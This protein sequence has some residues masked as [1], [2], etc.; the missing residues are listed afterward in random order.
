MSFSIVHRNQA[1]AD[2]GLLIFVR[3]VARVFIG[4]PTTACASVFVLPAIA[5]IVPSRDNH[6]FHPGCSFIP[7]ASSITFR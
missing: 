6:S 3:T 5:A 7:Y 2:F 1:N 4:V